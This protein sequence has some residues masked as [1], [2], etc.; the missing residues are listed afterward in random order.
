MPKMKKTENSLFIKK[1]V[2]YFG[3]FVAITTLFF[4]WGIAHGMLDTLDKNF[5]LML[6]LKK[7]QSSFIQF[8][9]YGAYFRNGN[10]C[11]FIYEKARV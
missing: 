7:W 4:L 2:N 10:T 5:Q 9:L 11:R 3:P 1:G 8:S 6:H